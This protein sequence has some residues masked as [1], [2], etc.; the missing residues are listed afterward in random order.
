M[1][2]GEYK[3]SNESR[4]QNQPDAAGEHET[5]TTALVL[6]VLIT[7]AV[8][9][10]ILVYANQAN[11]SQPQ[12][13]DPVA[14]TTTKKA[15][16]SNGYT[17]PTSE[18]ETTDVSGQSGLPEGV[19]VPSNAEIISSYRAAF[20]NTGTQRVLI[21]DTQSALNQIT[22][23]YETSLTD[24]GFSVDTGSQQ[25][26]SVTL[27]SSRGADELIVSVTQTQD[28]RRVQFNYVTQ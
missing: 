15:E 19:S 11:Q 14:T 13:P 20:G 4:R 9:A 17:V 1:P 5:H 25:T 8:I 21:Y 3:Q 6:L 16:P 18:V 23:T 22:D 2:E 12:Q 24:A 28:S 10:I 7:V 26:D 27:K